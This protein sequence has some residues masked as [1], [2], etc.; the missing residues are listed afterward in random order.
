MWKWRLFKN[1]LEQWSPTLWAPE[2][3]IVEDNFSTD[4]GWQGWF[5]EDFKHIIFTVPF[6]YCSWDSCGKTTGVVGHSLLQWTTFCQ[7]SPLWPVHLGWPCTVWLIASLSYASP[8]AT[9]R[10]WSMKQRMR[11]LDSITDSMGMNLGKLWE[12][13]RDREAWHAAVQKVT[14]S[15]TRLSDWT[16]KWKWKSLSRVRLLVIPWTIYSM[17]FSRP[18]H[19]S[20]PADLPNPGTEPV[21][22]ALQ[23][24]SLPAESPG[25]PTT[26]LLCTL[27]LL[28]HQ[29][30]SDHG[31]LDPGG[32]EPLA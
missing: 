15:W 22:P 21:S 25:K 26:Y 3:G 20:S 17:E 1:P 12:M 7:K 8:L 13:V 6:L 11:W 23:V 16:I 19:F 27:F 5:Q 30:H 14:K 9:T 4:Q 32:W 2:P 10:L 31:A 18:E 29:F 24:D 28:L